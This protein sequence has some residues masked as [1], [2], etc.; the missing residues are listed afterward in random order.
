MWPIALGLLFLGLLGVVIV[1]SRMNDS[2]PH[3]RALDPRPGPRRAKAEQEIL[4][5]FK[6]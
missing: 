2:A 5:V 3:R 1:C 4:E 6:V